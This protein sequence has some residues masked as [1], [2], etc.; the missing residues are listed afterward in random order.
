MNEKIK[1]VIRL[2]GTLVGVLVG[3]VVYFI[4]VV[5]G[6]IWMAALTGFRDATKS[7]TTPTPTQ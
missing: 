2:L 3:F 6:V 4:G 5:V 7:N 1:V